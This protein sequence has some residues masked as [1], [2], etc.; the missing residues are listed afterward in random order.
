MSRI[1]WQRRLEEEEVLAD[2]MRRSKWKVFTPSW[3][4]EEADA[5]I[6]VES[7]LVRFR[8]ASLALC[9]LMMTTRLQASQYFLSDS[10]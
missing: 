6:T 5:V 10:I 2:V 9:S 4:E 1:S 7:I 8:Q 3:E